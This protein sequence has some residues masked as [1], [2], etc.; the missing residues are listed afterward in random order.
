MQTPDPNDRSRLLAVARGDAPADVRLAGGHVLCVHTDEWLDVDVLVAGDRVAALLERD[1]SG[2]PPA[3]TTID[4]TGQYVVPGFIDAHIH[5]ESSKLTVDGFAKLV[6]PRGTTSVVAEPHEIANVLGVAGTEWFMDSAANVPLSCWFMVPSCVPASDF[7]SA[8]AELDVDAMAQLLRHP[9]AIGVGELMNFPGMIAGDMQQLAKA[10]LGS[11]SHADGHAPNVRGRSLDAYIGAGIH[12]DHESTTVAE[13]LEKR[14]R[15]MWILMREASNARNLRDLA[16]LVLE[17]GPAF[18]AL[19]TDDREPDELLNQGHMDENIRIAISTGIA[20]EIAIRLAT[21]HPA[22][23]HNL[24][25]HGAITP[26]AYA[27]IVVLSDLNSVR[28]A[29]VMHHGVLVAADGEY[30]DERPA[31]PAPINVLDTVRMASITEADVTIRTNDSEATE[32]TA[33]VIGALDGQL[34]TEHRRAT[35][36][37]VDGV[38]EP[39]PMRDIAQL[40]CVERHTASGRVGSGF[41][42]GFGLQRGCFATTVAHDAHN[43][44][45][46][47]TDRASI[48]RAINRLAAIGGGLVVDDGTQ[49]VAQLALPIA[50]IMSDAEPSDVVDDLTGALA[51]VRA[52]GVTAES[53]FMVLSFLALSV[54]PS[55]KL[56]DRGYVDVDRFELVPT[57]VES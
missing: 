46:V 20:P 8:G 35:L 23:A 39:D 38:V 11:Q 49:V 13:A 45:A 54:I 52:L 15:G 26:G 22:L 44:V 42:Q 19:C 30:V 27:D 18:C 17:F 5:I 10:R 51:A 21:L 1:D 4:V 55:L 34:L 16:P 6:V 47:G 32:V 9:R 31:Q 12:S 2:I 33:R 3:S 53:P 29:R 37:V 14:R 41:V 28:V 56:T 36:M 50:G 43:I 40:V 24:R 7:E 25:D 48:L 57:L